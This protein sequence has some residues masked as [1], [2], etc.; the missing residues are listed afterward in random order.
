M[1]K[2]SFALT[3]NKNLLYLATCIFLSLLLLV[4]PSKLKTDLSGLIF[5]F[6]YAPFYALS[7][8]IK[9]LKGVYQENKRLHQR[10]ME[11]TLENSKLKEESLENSRLRAL[12]EFRSKLRYQVI[13][14]EVVAAEPNRPFGTGSVLVNKGKEEGIKRNMPVLNLHGMVG[15]IAEVFPHRSTV[16]L[17]LDPDFRVSALDQRSRVFGIIKPHP[18][19]G[20]VLK[21]DNVPAG[22]DVRRG[23]EVISA[24]LGGIFPAGIRIGVVSRVGE[25]TFDKTNPYSGIFKEI[26]VKPSVD[27]NSLEELFV[28]NIDSERDSS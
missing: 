9:Q 8:Q 12:L 24:G 15:K 6:S 28:L 18:R 4:L 16:Q 26:E 1:N 20:V 21:L 13:P 3:K 22:E 11:L 19:H 23:D 5:R 2:I 10:V 25:R 27:F 7:H 14:T 17:M